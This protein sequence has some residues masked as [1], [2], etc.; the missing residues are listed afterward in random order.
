MS[1]EDL[2]APVQQSSWTDQVSFSEGVF[3]ISSIPIRYY[4][5]SVPLALLTRAFRLVED[6]PGSE[7]WGYDAI[8]QRDIDEDRVKEELLNDYLLIPDKFKFFN[9]LTIALLPYEAAERR[10]L[11]SYRGDTAMEQDGRL[12]V[13]KIDGIE[14]V[15]APA[16]PVGNI[17]WDTNR[18]VATAI[19]G[20]HRLSA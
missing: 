6:I 2:S 18:I 20:Q 1:L 14:I 9:P 7:D 12:T 16:A 15:R 5:T 10:I 4:L 8:F 13:E 19:D 17:R 11:D 3:D